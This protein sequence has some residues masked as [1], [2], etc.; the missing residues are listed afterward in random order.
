MNEINFYL[1]DLLSKFLKINPDEYYLRYSGGADSH[2][3]F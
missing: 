1:E 3:L 2:L